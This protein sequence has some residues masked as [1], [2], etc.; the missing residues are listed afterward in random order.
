[1]RDIPVEIR[2]RRWSANQCMAE[3]SVFVLEWGP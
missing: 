3:F 1:M 2:I